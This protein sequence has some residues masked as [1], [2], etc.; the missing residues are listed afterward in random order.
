[1]SDDERS[2]RVLVL[3]AHR[4]QGVTAVRSLGRRGL[5][6][7]AASDRRLNSGGL[8][9]CAARRFR[10]PSPNDEAAFCRAVE[11]ELRS[12]QY[13]MLLPLTAVTV[14]IVVRNRKR[15]EP[16]TDL[17]FLP[18]EDLLVGLDKYRTFRAAR[19]AGV[20]A[21]ETV[22]P[23]VLDAEAVTKRLGLPVVVKPRRGAGGFGVHVCETEAEL[24]MAFE[25]VRES[26][27]APIV[28]EF[29]PNGGEFGVYTIYD[30][31]SELRGVTV[32]RRLRTNPPGGGASTLRET[33]SRPDLIR[34]ADDLF[35]SVGWRGVAMAEFRLDPRSDRPMLLEVNP[36]LWGSLTLSVFAGTDFPYLLYQLS[37]TDTCD[38]SLAYRVGVQ[39]R[40]LTGEVGH[41]L[42]REDRWR[43][44]GEMLAPADAPRMYDAFALR[45]PLPGVSHL[46]R[47][48]SALLHE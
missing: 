5:A 34:T 28:Q 3:E 42:A 17:P 9:R 19:S 44:A 16:Y 13:D 39:A 7:T 32:Q 31:S 40:N 4:R 14:P 33:V 43:A 22:A 2:G 36:R 23:E 35:T 15:F 24:T 26:H 37:T 11:R 45:D 8:S 18:Y 21:P 25:S 20:P 1:M 27:G 10:Y 47:A 48:G 29:V 38:R 46:L 12:R 30:S 41:L 6:V